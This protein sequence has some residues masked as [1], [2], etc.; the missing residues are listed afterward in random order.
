MKTMKELQ[1]RLKTV[2]V[3]LM[4]QYKKFK[5]GMRTI[6][7]KNNPVRNSLRIPA[8][9]RA[10]KFTVP[11]VR[12]VTIDVTSGEALRNLVKDI[13]NVPSSQEIWIT[14]EGIKKIKGEFKCE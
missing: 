14:E 10:G 11:E 4:N 5:R 8:A 3:D 12:E 13:S 7:R 9:R 1:E 2:D 6:R